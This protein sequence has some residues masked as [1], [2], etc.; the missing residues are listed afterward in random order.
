[1]DYDHL[2]CGTHVRV[3]S[4]AGW[5]E[6]LS[7]YIAQPRNAFIEVTI[8][9]E[10]QSSSESIEDP[11]DPDYRDVS[12]FSSSVES[13]PAT[14]GSTYYVLLDMYKEALTLLKGRI[15]DDE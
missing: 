12:P 13:E 7:D 11:D 14:W 5:S 9:G 8:R 4:N 10:Y 15:G 3:V 2:P 1:M 6:E